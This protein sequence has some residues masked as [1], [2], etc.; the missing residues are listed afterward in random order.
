MDLIEN[1]KI[2]VGSG[3]Y[4]CPIVISTLYQLMWPAISHKLAAPS[5][6]ISMPLAI[7]VIGNLLFVMPFVTI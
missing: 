1:F 4:T 7:Y 6:V 2:Q 3:N 5:K